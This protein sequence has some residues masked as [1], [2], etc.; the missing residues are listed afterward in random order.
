MQRTQGSMKHLQN[1]YPGL[2]ERVV[3]SLLAALVVSGPGISIAI[4]LY[5]P[6]DPEQINAF[7][8]ILQAGLTGV[9]FLLFVFQR[10]YMLRY[11]M[12][13]LFMFF[14]ACYVLSSLRHQAAH[15]FVELDP[16]HFWLVVGPL[17]L[18]AFA[19]AICITPNPKSNYGFSIFSIFAIC[20]AVMCL[21]MITNSITNIRN[22]TVYTES[23][24]GSLVFGYFASYAIAIAVGILLS[25]GLTNFQR[26][27][28]V[29]GTIFCL[30]ILII[31]YSRGGVISCVAAILYAMFCKFARR[32]GALNYLY[33][34]VGVAGFVAIAVAYMDSDLGARVA[35]ISNRIASGDEARVDI[36]LTIFELSKSS[37]FGWGLEV[38]DFNHPHNIVI[39]VLMNMGIAGVFLLIIVIYKCFKGI[40]TN[41]DLL[42]NLWIGSLF[43]AIFTGSLFSSTL[44]LNVAVWFAMAMVTRVR[45][46]PVRSAQSSSSAQLP[47]SSRPLVVG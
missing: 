7:V 44:Y 42:D 37:I 24:G 25:G 8:R 17:V 28:T 12:S 19:A 43:C 30:Y 31:S 13:Y 1:V 21:Y 6:R 11:R 20:A 18:T 14:Y 36:W 26:A 34:A 4:S 33:F 47:R 16:S 29:A 15:P 27:L 9:L 23:I 2:L 41:Q 38:P 35:N 5:A 46:S 22:Y 39:E 45:R 10:R 40:L 3:V 32:G